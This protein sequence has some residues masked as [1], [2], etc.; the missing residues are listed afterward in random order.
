MV[1]DC[2][3]I[4]V[5]RRQRRQRRP[6]GA[7][8]PDPDPDPVLFFPLLRQ[9]TDRN[10]LRKEGYILVYSLRAASTMAGKAQ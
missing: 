7:C 3:S 2:E 8:Q 1:K 6:G 4:Y 10:N 9:N 5:A